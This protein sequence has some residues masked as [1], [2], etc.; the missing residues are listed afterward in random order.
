MSCNMPITPK[1]S[2]FGL[3]NDESNK[4]ITKNISPIIL[5]KNSSV[6]NYMVSNSIEDNQKPEKEIVY[7]RIMRNYT[8]KKYKN[9]YIEETKEFRKE[10]KR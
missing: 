6:S 2:K 5:N 8:K 4:I 7:G 9:K 10:R 1:N 3:L